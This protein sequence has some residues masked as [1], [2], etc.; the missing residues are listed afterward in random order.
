M[1]Y[2][3]WGFPGGGKSYFATRRAY[4]AMKAGKKVF[5][6][7]PVMYLQKP[8]LFQR[9]L[10]IF[11]KKENR[12]ESHVV[13]SYVWKSSYLKEYIVGALI[14]I[15]E[16][17]RDYSSRNWQKFTEDIHTNFA[18]NRHNDNDFYFIIVDV[19]RF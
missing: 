19:G 5:T 2:I 15:D 1:I 10:N 18:T 17:Y 8:S 4:H 6:N 16:A 3:I 7:Y 12:R 13:S 14:I 11:R 9:F